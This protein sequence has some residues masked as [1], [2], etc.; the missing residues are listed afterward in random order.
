MLL[1]VVNSFLGVLHQTDCPISKC[2]H[3]INYSLLYNTDL[4]SEVRVKVFLTNIIVHCQKNWSSL[5]VSPIIPSVLVLLAGGWKYEK[6]FNP[7]KFP[8]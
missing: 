1:K 6:S 5:P 8:D 7:M 3:K 2:S 4:V